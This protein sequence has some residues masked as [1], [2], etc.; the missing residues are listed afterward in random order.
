[1]RKFLC[2]MLAVGMCLLG[3]S[4]AGADSTVETVYERAGDSTNFGG[5][6]E[7]YQARLGSIQLPGGDGASAGDGAAGDGG[8]GASGGSGGG[9]GGNGGDGC[10]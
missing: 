8:A 2:A 4:P 6:A 5:T 7:S 9:T 1:M 3:V 10:K